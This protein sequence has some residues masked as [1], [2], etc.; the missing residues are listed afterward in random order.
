[1]EFK[2]CNMGHIISIDNNDCPYCKIVPKFEEDKVQEEEIF[3]TKL[4]VINN[5]E[6]VVAWLVNISGV[7]KGLDYRLIEG[8]NFIG[9]N[10]DA[11]I[12][13]LGDENID[14]KNHFSISYNKKQRDFVI[15]PGNSQN[16]IYVNKKALYETKHID[17]FSLIEVSDTKLVFVKF[18]G[19]NFS[20]DINV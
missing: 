9:K 11:D 10:K 4:F 3:K 14:E 7:E 16:I 17:N 12:C 8:R 13:I 19:D 6:P 2:K 1:M 20:W 15:T 5:L 18:V